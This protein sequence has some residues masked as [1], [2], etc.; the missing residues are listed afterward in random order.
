MSVLLFSGISC[1]YALAIECNFYVNASELGKGDDYDGTSE[2]KAWN[3]I[4]QVNA[5]MAS[6]VPGD[7][8]CLKRGEVFNRFGLELTNL[9]GTA[10]QPLLFGAYGDESAPLPILEGSRAMETGWISLGNSLYTGR[11]QKDPLLVTEGEPEGAPREPNILSYNGVSKP[12]ISTITLKNAPAEIAKNTILTLPYGTFWVDSK[13]AS[14]VSGIYTNITPALKSAADITAGQLV[15][16]LQYVANGQEITLT[17]SW[18]IEQVITTGAAARGGLNEPGQWYWD[19]SDKRIYL[20]SNTLPTDDTV[21]AS[22]VNFG[23]RVE[24]KPLGQPS[25][26]II[27]QDIKVRNFNKQGVVL[28][29]SSNI[30]VQRLNISGCTYNGIQMWNTSESMIKDNTIDSNTDGI[31]LYTQP[32][33]S[34]NDQKNSINNQIQNNTITNSRGRGISLLR[35]KP[36]GNLSGNVISSNTINGSNSMIDG[37][38]GVYTSYAGPNTIRDNFIRNGGSTYLRS[39]GILIDLGGDPITITSNTIEDNSA[40]GIAVAGNGHKI[41]ANTLRNN[42]VTY[43]ERPQIKFFNAGFDT[44]ASNCIVTGNTIEAFAGYRFIKIGENS[45]S[46]HTI[47]YNTYR[48]KASAD[49]HF[50]LPT[51]HSWIDFPTWQ[52]RTGHDVNSSCGRISSILKLINAIIQPRFKE[53]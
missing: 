4:L 48:Y 12:P 38:A 22:W 40:A 7:H 32:Q 23:I 18:E 29:N 43:M 19:T 42:G 45:E 8:I 35:S 3:S 1:K 34:E 41:T 52:S 49:G 37:G 36:A 11:P 25:Q 53:R 30:T 9:D 27:I 51:G 13:T 16:S 44:G 5:A 24:P 46:D 33:L 2:A 28:F 20:Y 6:F 50:L 14:Q 26:H 21:L 15:K 17:G 10:D 47:N 39:T 31:V